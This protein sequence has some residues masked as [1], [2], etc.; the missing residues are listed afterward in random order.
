MQLQP[1]DLL[2]LI[3]FSFYGSGAVMGILSGV[4]SKV[5]TN[6]YVAGVL[7]TSVV[8]DPQTTV[9]PLERQRGWEL[10]KDG[11]SALSQQEE[12]LQRDGFS[13]WKIRET[14]IRWLFWWFSLKSVA[15]VAGHG[16]IRGRCGG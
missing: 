2:H 9:A 13:L 4:L 11:F 7:P 3:H 5:N 10:E 14:R 16:V 8:P 1:N 12:P 6:G 15:E